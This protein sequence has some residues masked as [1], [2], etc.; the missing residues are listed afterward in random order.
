M[1]STEFK[2]QTDVGNVYINT[3]QGQIDVRLQMPP[4]N[5]VFEGNCEDYQYV[6]LRHSEAEQEKFLKFLEELRDQLDSLLY[7]AQYHE[8]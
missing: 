4:K 2:T 3:R 8:M 7:L 5:I 1:K 6:T